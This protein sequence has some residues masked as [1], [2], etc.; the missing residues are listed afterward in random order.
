MSDNENVIPE[1]KRK[2]V[3]GYIEKEYEE[4]AESIEKLI[5]KIYNNNENII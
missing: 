5:L 2:I 3:S 1:K 4:I